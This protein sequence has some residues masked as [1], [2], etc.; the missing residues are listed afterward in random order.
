MPLFQE[1]DHVAVEPDRVLE[2]LEDG[3]AVFN[4][5][6][7]H[8]ADQEVVVDPLFVDERGQCLDA[9]EVDSLYCV[10]HKCSNFR[11][12]QRYAFSFNIFKSS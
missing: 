2:G 8:F 4:P 3:L 1:E 5:L 11:F 7:A 9:L 10:I 6:P 12:L